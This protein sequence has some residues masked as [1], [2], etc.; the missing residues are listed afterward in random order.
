MFLIEFEM[1]GTTREQYEKIW[2][3]LAQ[4]DL[5]AP[6]GRSH[7]FGAPAPGG[8]RV[9]DVW[10]DMGDF[11]AFGKVLIPAMVAAGITPPQPRVLPI[12]KAV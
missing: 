4:Q 12:V 5:L 11:E 10:T 3:I 1:P 9:I 7:H 6:R 2:E 8:W